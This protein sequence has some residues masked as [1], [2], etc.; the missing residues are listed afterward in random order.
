MCF[1]RQNVSNLIY[2]T[3]K[4]IFFP[5]SSFEKIKDGCEIFFKWSYIGYFNSIATFLLSTEALLLAHL[6]NLH[7]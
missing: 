5:G 4:W 3:G 1:R 7:I 6:K 2:I